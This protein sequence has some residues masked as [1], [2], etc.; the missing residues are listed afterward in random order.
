MRFG[1]CQLDTDKRELRCSGTLVEMEPQVFDVLSY[2]IEHR[3]RVVP[4]TELLDTVWG[5]RFVSESAL[6]S[7]IKSARKAVGDNGRDQRIIKTIHRKGYRFIAPVSDNAAPGDERD[8]VAAIVGRLSSGEGGTWAIEGADGREKTELVERIHTAAERSGIPVG[9]SSCAG[10]GLIRFRCVLR[11]LDTLIS[12]LGPAAPSLP[13]PVAAELRRTGEAGI[14]SSR[15]RLFLTVRE[16]VA[17][18]CSAHPCMIILEGVEYVDAETQALITH[19]QRLTAVHALAL[20]VAHRPGLPW[21]SAATR[22]ELESAE[23]GWTHLSAPSEL[24]EPLQAV[25]LGGDSFDLMEFRAAT[26]LRGEPSDKILQLG[27][28]AG[29]IVDGEDGLLRFRDH[30]T[31][32]K[33]RELVP[34]YRRQEL[35]NTTAR[36]LAEAGA[37]P[38][39]VG[40]RFL[41]GDHPEE[42]VPFAVAAAQQAAG[43]GFHRDVLFWTEKGLE[44]AAGD[45][46]LELLSLRG[47]SLTAAG[48]PAAVTAFREALRVAPTRELPVLRARLARAAMLS[49]DTATAAEALEG[50]EAEGNPGD[51]AILL[52]R[53]MLSYLRGDVETTARLVEQARPLVLAPDTP[54]QMLDV[55]VL[56]GLVAH[57]RGEWFD[58][59]RSEL[60]TTRS[61][62]ALASSIFDNH[63]CVAEYLLYG[64]TPN[65]EITRMGTE[66]RDLARDTGA[67][68]AE[69]FASCVIGEADYLA[70]RLDEAR[71]N[72]QDAVGVY[73]ELTAD[74]GAAHSLQRLAEVELAM[75]NRA[76]AEDLARRALRQGRWSTMSRHVLPRIYGTLIRTAPN[77]PGG[78][79]VAEEA[80]EVLDD[81]TSCVFCQVMIQVP[82][83]NV[84]ASAGYPDRAEEHLMRARRSAMMW[85]GSAWK[86]AIA[87]ASATIAESRGDMSEAD[88]LLRN[89]ALLYEEA[90]QPLD[91]ARC[92]A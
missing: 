63:L 23:P 17:G 54:S 33:L 88:R 69:A 92:R 66:L 55:I 75:G 22:I 18:A 37:A 34:P 11:A 2:L 28:T 16:V 29:L 79:T 8:I 24:V 30:A 64:P 85:K 27:L 60:Q 48:D 13:D 1:E 72:L 59:V 47:W 77:I 52:A 87:E 70:G 36:R 31:A 76:E 35:H 89:A 83:A 41:A 58:R 67:R 9:R 4:K 57:D 12:R 46:R 71:S 21:F 19:I 68:R 90:E 40:R 49:G 6:T 26:G 78:V 42:V 65:T 25:A 5:S 81:P 10:D 56:S 20:V 82:L 32:D 61:N 91:A 53:A 45:S 43:A 84:W 39:R 73:R 74:A 44:H 80:A 86:A 15:P 7:R 50:L 38:D 62:P 14:P 51:A 3:D